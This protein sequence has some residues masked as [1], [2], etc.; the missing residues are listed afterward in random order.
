MTDCTKCYK[1]IP[2]NPCDLLSEIV[3][4]EEEIFY[5]PICKDW[6]ISYIKDETEEFYGCGECGNIWKNI[7]E[8][9]K[10][11]K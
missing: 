8:I 3:P 10:Y 2:I 7:D 6:T 9:K 5:C 4:D 11:K 1:N